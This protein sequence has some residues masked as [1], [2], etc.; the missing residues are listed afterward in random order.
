MRSI[1]GRKIFRN[2][3]AASTTS[4]QNNRTLVRLPSVLKTRIASYLNHR[5]AICLNQTSKVFHNDIRLSSLSPSYELMYSQIWLGETVAGDVPCRGEMIPIFSSRPHSVTLTCRWRDQGWGERKGRLY[6]VGETKSILSQDKQQQHDNETNE[7]DLFHGGKVICESPLAPH[8]FTMM[9]LSFAPKINEKYYLWYRCG[10][11]GG[12]LLMVENLIVHTL[13]FDDDEKSTKTIY[14]RLCS[15]GILDMGGNNNDDGSDD[16]EM[17]FGENNDDLVFYTKLFI[18]VIESFLKEV[19]GE[20]EP[21][22][23]S[24][25]QS[26]L[27]LNGLQLNPSALETMRTVCHFFLQ[28][29]DHQTPLSMETWRA[30]DLRTHNQTEDQKEIEFPPF[31]LI[32]YA[33]WEG[34]DDSGNIP[35]Q[36]TRIPVI[37]GSTKS[38]RITCVWKDEGYAISRGQLFVIAKE[39]KSFP[40]Y[41]TGKDPTLPFGGGRVVW[42]SPTV[43]HELSFLDMSFV[44]RDD[45]IYYI[46]QKPGGE[47][48]IHIEDLT[49]HITIQGGDASALALA[50]RSLIVCGALN[51]RDEDHSFHFRLLV[52][53]TASLLKAAKDDGC[54]QETALAAF[55]ES[56]GFPIH[57]RALRPLQEM[58]QCLIEFHDQRGTG[59]LVTSTQNV[60]H[61]DSD[62]ELRF[63]THAAM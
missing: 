40:S 14:S 19:N 2:K 5:D 9:D 12:H 61:H 49:M 25:L 24:I 43:Q 60:D 29:C 31:I 7:K 39:G 58:L 52:A 44:P 48:L 8:E 35:L 62:G 55:F 51:R 30:G 32:P 54:S 6:I 10:G 1:A 33:T 56:N 18:K 57:N 36:C 47:H 38:V 50:F 27:E 26:F 11:G 46:F 59:N 16:D 41:E 42:E 20:C 3:M 15:L 45:E 22:H 21:L 13:A 28:Y 37:Y 4:N 17:V 63:R 23:F 53:A 34:D